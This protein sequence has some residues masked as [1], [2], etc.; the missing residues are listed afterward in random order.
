L[1]LLTPA[2]GSLQQSRFDLTGLTIARLNG[3]QHPASTSPQRQ[4]RWFPEK[5]SASAADIGSMEQR[6]L[7]LALL[8]ASEPSGQV[9]KRFIE[10]RYLD[11]F[12]SNAPVRY[13]HLLVLSDNQGN[14]AAALGIRRAS[15]GPLFLEQYLDVPAEQAIEQAT[16]D[17]PSRA[18]IVEL[19]SFAADSSR[20]ATYLITAM[21]AYMQHQSF[22]HALVTSTGRLRRLFALFGFDLRSLGDARKDALPDGGKA[23]GLY[24]DDA[25]L[26]LAG[27]VPECFET[28]LR[29]RDRQ[30]I[31]ARRNIIDDLV[32]QARTLPTC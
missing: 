7:K 29:E 27:S 8:P 6:Q 15:E 14:T 22:S 13:P 19:G 12:G 4:A 18:G 9:A 1:L 3:A 16:G 25:P 26:V 24:Y 23:W 30:P 5:P 20:T 31:A 17:A 28:V 32:V 11:M 10:A 2:S 21:A